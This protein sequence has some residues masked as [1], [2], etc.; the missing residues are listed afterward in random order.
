MNGNGFEQALR[1]L[2][3]LQELEREGQSESSEADNIRDSMD[4]YWGWCADKSKQLTNKEHEVLQ[5]VSVALREG[6]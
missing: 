2:L 6:A 1:L 4:P 3:R 5:Q